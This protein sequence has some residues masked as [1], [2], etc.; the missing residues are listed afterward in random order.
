[1]LCRR[2]TKALQHGI[3]IGF[4]Y[5]RKRASD[6]IVLRF[7]TYAQE[8]PSAVGVGKGREGFRQLVCLDRLAL[9]F[10]VPSLL[11]VVKDFQVFHT[12][13]VE[14]T[15]ERRVEGHS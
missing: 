7:F 6:S 13:L 15:S 14:R 4:R 2:L 9:V 8:E 10:D 3:G 11:R 5:A 1:M 12:D